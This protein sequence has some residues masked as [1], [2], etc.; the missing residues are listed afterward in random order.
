MS[1][2]GVRMKRGVLKSI[3]AGA[4]LEY[5]VLIGIV[6]LAV[7]AVLPVYFKRGVQGRL[8]DLTDDF[9][10]PEQVQDPY[11]KTSTNPDEEVFSNSTTTSFVNTTI[12]K[13][14]LE[15]G[16]TKLQTDDK[17]YIAGESFFKES[18]DDTIWGGITLYTDPTVVERQDD[19]YIDVDNRDWENIRDIKELEEI[20][21]SYLEQAA[22][23]REGR[24]YREEESSAIS[25]IFNSNWFNLLLTGDLDIL[26]V[27]NEMVNTS[28]NEQGDLD[29]MNSR[30][31]ELEYEAD[32]IDQRIHCLQADPN[33]DCR[34]G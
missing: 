32:L 21:D 26:D 23:I 9:I 31:E 10:S 7:S 18:V 8:K 25:G 15:G 6:A 4:F 3:R 17:R 20:R 2:K 29:D 11:K 30:A 24:G 14:M 5:A 28:N 1:A 19:E 34:V 16:S 12:T 27:L 13:K 33:A 22:R